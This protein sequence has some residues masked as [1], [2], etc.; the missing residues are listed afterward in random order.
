MMAVSAKRII[1]HKWEHGTEKFY[2]LDHG[3]LASLA[4]NMLEICVMLGYISERNIEKGEWELRRDILWLHDA[5]TRYKMF[6]FWGDRES[7]AGSKAHI[8]EIRKRISSHA[9]F[10]KLPA[11]RREKILSGSEVYLHGLR[12]TARALG[13]DLNTFNGAYAYLSGYSHSSPVSFIRF[14]DH[15]IN[16]HRPSSAQFAIAGVSLVFANMALKTASALILEAFPHIMHDNPHM[17]FGPILA[18]ED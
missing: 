15:G 9:I 11:D 16:A 1:D 3:T 13:W 12:P 18:V 7:A 17:D 6:K 10:R 8:P 5:I 2:T 14:Y 4:R